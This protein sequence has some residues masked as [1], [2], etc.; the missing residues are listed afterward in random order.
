M[1]DAAANE[2]RIGAGEL[3][4]GGAFAG[5]VVRADE[6]SAVLELLKRDLGEAVLVTAE[7]SATA[8]APILPRLAGVVCSSGG[9]AAHLAI[10][11]RGLDLP[12]VM[13]AELE[14]WPEPGEAIRV[15]DDGG[16]WLG[17]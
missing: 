12:C 13:K 4:S 5:E 8:F 6:I 7:A 16:V 14:R 9:E 2:V 10:V 11:S 15:D 3:Q 17:R 1:A